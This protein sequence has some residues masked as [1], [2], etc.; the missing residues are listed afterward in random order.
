MLPHDSKPGRGR[1]LKTSDVECKVVHKH[2]ID[3]TQ[4]P[5]AEQEGK[6][7]IGCH[8]AK[9]TAD[10]NNGIKAE[11]SLIELRKRRQYSCLGCEQLHCLIKRCK[12]CDHVD[13][14]KVPERTKEED[15]R[16]DGF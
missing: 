10:K 1:Q 14:S 16:D 8:H 3:L 12:C 5:A 4:E 11:D 7:T 2:V 9:T 6:P 15:D 13:L